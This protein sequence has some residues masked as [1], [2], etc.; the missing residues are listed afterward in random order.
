MV[1]VKSKK[2]TAKETSKV[3]RIAKIDAGE[4]N[5]IMG[6]HESY[7]G[8]DSEDIKNSSMAVAVESREIS[9]GQITEVAYAHSAGL[10]I[11]IL[12][13]QPI[14]KEEK[15]HYQKRLVGAVK[16]LLYAKEHAESVE[17]RAIFWKNFKKIGFTPKN[18][19]E[20]DGLCNL[21]KEDVRPRTFGEVV[22]ILNLD[23]EF[24]FNTTIEKEVE[25]WRKEN[26]VYNQEDN[27]LKSSENSKNEMAGMIGTYAV[28]R[29]TEIVR[30][31]DE[32]FSP[33]EAIKEFQPEDKRTRDEVLDETHKRVYLNMGESPTSLIYKNR[34]SVEIDVLGNLRKK[35]NW[36]N[37]A[38]RKT[39]LAMKN[40]EKSLLYN[41]RSKQINPF[42]GIEAREKAVAESRTNM[43]ETSEKLS[44]R[45]NRVVDIKSAREKSYVAK[46]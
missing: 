2:A 20:I 16:H 15:T 26:G 46:K 23:K 27:N 28:E 33:E 40:D 18:L 29:E 9:R 8:R 31:I 4:M 24:F 35:D 13:I 39:Y 7:V 30:S 11:S 22:D 36:I 42:A 37:K 41:G 19:H 6:F 32:I 14:E 43:W 5:E 10:P 38:H 44:Y 12:E 25:K 45:S 3:N 34:N 1:K 17:Y 21:I